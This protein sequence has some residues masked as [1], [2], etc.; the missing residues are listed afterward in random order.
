MEKEMNIILMV[1][2]YLK[3]NIQM[4]KEMEKEQNIIIVV[5]RDLKV[6]I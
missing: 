5:I 2:Y 3:V 6:N 4:E 1:N